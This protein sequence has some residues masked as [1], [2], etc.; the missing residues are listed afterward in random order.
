MGFLLEPCVIQPGEAA[1]VVNDG[2]ILPDGRTVT[3][4]RNCH[5]AP[6][7]TLRLF[8]RE[9]LPTMPAP[10][11]AEPTASEATA[12]ATEAP[13]EATE[14]T[15]E[16]LTSAGELQGFSVGDNPLAGVAL[17]AL[18]VLGGGAAWKFYQ[19][20]SEQKHEQ[21]MKKM[22]LDAA[23]AGMNGAQPPPCQAAQIK[24][25]QELASLRSQLAEIEKKTSLNVSSGG[26]SAEEL[27][28]RIKKLEKAKK[29]K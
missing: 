27:E 12:E 4:S 23:N 2:L 6:G 18:A 7:S 19:K 22:E 3:D 5:F 21:A 1:I 28:N 20:I 11:K 29:Q 15:V 24:V 13:A 10:K 26:P 16:P 9:P 8:Y 14:G 17:A 25:E